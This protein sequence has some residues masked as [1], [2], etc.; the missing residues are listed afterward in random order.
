MWVQLGLAVLLAFLNEKVI[1]YFAM[2]EKVHKGLVWGLTLGLALFSYVGVTDA[3]LHFLVWS[4]LLCV[5]LI[6]YYTQTI[7]DAMIYAIGL[8]VLLWYFLAGL[9]SLDV[10]LGAAFG[11]VFYGLIYWLAKLYYKREAFGFGDVMLMG[12]IGAYL[13][14]YGAV[15]SSFLSFYLALLG[16]VLGR[17]IGKRFKITETIAF[18]PFVCLAGILMAVYGDQIINWYFGRLLF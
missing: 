13:G 2:G 14:L 15:L 17:V 4:A 10:L 18:G 6:D 1:T 16:L 12:V 7:V 9:L 11:F 3:V 8:G 5:A